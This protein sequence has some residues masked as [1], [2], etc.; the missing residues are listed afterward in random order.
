[1]EA[2]ETKREE[3]EIL[4]LFRIGV[5]IKAGQG[6]IELVA[7]GFL[8]FIPL[9]AITHIADRFT[10]VE[11]ARDP[12]DFV[13]THIADFAHSISVGAKDFAVIYLLLNGLIKLV[14]AIALLTGKRWAY[15]VA[16]PALATFIVYLIYRIYLHHSPLLA[17]AALLDVTVFY[18]IWREYQIVLRKE[19]TR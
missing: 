19:G 2:S 1:M 6:L 11:L 3:R 14:L 4:D 12:D 13:A 15:P 7:S 8:F 9:E 18:F 10:E 17:V 5:L 16:L